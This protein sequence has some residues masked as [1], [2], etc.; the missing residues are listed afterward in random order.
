MTGG[1]RFPKG[2][3]IMEYRIFFGKYIGQPI[4]EIPSSYLC[5]V[6]ESYSDCDHSLRTACKAE[7]A[8]RLSL[9]FTPTSNR[10]SELQKQLLICENQFLHYQRICIISQFT[11]NPI[12]LQGY[13]S[14]PKML[15]ADLFFRL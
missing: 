7:L 4:S 5:W 11:Q 1:C 2:F 3:F 6:L 15:E 12:R 8:H 13:E 14:N 10:E 9:D